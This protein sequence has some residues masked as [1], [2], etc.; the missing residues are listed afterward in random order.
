MFWILAICTGNEIAAYL[1]DISG[2]FGRVYKDYLLAKLQASRVG[3]R[4]LNFL[5]AYLKPRKVVVAVEGVFSDDIEI[6]NTVF[7]GTVLGPPLW[8]VRHWTA[9]GLKNS[10]WKTLA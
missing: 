6:A 7:Q 5:D 9:L 10:R 1:G 8:N 2:A 3:S 4:Y